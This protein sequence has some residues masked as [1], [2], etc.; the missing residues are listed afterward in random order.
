[1]S[2]DSKLKSYYLGE[3]IP[4]VEKIKQVQREIRRA[5]SKQCS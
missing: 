3:T 5:A 4:R 1:M 2:K